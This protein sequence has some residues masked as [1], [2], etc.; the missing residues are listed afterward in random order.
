MKT[1]SEAGSGGPELPVVEVVH[2]PFNEQV[3]LAAALVSEA[4]R[5]RYVPQLRSELFLG[6][7]HAEVWDALRGLH[8]RGLE[9]SLAAVRQ[10]AGVAVDE[11]YLRRLVE[12]HP[13]APPNVAH[14]V[15]MLQWDRA[16]ASAV[17]GPVGALLRALQDPTTDPERVRALGRQVA[18]C[19]EGHGDRRY[20]H[21]PAQLVKAQA[22]KIRRRREGEACY[23]Y[24]IPTLDQDEYGRW[25]MVPGAAPGQ[26]TVITA[27][28]GAGKSTLVGQI[29]LGLARQKRRVLCGSWEQGGGVTLELMALQSLGWSRMRSATGQLTDEEIDQLE[30]RMGKISSFVR[31]WKLPVGRDPGESWTNDG[32]LDS[33]HAHIAD[34]GCDVAIFDL[35]ERALSNTRPEEERR[36]LY[37]MQTILDETQCHGI[38]VQQ[39][40]LK[41]V[42][43]RPDK[44]PTRDG[45]FGSAAWVEVADT[46]MG[47]HNPALFKDM[48]ADQL[49]LDILKQRYG[50]WPLAVEFKWNPDVGVISSGRSVEY[51]V[52]PEDA[53]M[54]DGLAGWVRGKKKGKAAEAD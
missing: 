51:S 47:V 46:I 38:L 12:S 30:E 33:I 23:P 16:R 50:K 2:D 26:I 37:R 4:V 6:Q 9:C 8:Q 22:D 17:S 29:A 45:I 21:D 36:A 41:D 25:R 32:A 20:M 3:V 27:V 49:E 24:G 44:R 35:F 10:V 28:S 7:G 5:K 39:Q 53:E 42:E 54:A 14:H 48:P 1:R 13:V 18:Q 40:R 19:F 43:T 52:A 15:S 34:S 31:F 11:S